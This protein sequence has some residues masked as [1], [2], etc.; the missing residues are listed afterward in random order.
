MFCTIKNVQL[1]KIYYKNMDK[2]Q[3]G[4]MTA[5]EGF[6]NEQNICDKFNN[7]KVDIEG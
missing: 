5:K 6:I 4:S 2:V 3:I 1:S 7:W